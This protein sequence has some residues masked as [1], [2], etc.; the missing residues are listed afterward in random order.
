MRLFFLVLNCV[1]SPRNVGRCRARSQL[2]GAAL[3]MIPRRCSRLP[4]F[5]PQAF[6]IEALSLLCSDFGDEALTQNR[7]FLR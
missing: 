3:L 7:I 2:P 4:D 1:P 6:L 5:A